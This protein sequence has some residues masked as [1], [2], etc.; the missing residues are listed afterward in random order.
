[1]AKLRSYKVNIERLRE[2]RLQKGWTMS[3]LARIMKMEVS[4]TARWENGKNR[5]R[6]SFLPIVAETLGVEPS[7]LIL[8]DEGR[9]ETPAQ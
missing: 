9:S 7:E 1:M 2:L 4:T 5:M 6:A 3:D 8:A